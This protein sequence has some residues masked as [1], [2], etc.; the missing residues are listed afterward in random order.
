MTLKERKE[1][2]SCPAWTYK[3]VML[4]CNTK[5]S[6]AFEIIALCKQRLNGSVTFDKHK[7]KRDSVLAYC[8]SSIERERYVIAQLEKQEQEVKENT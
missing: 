1:L 3:Q 4:Y 2:L 5:K 7:V 8:G 6:K